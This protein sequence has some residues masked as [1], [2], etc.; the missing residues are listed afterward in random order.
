MKHALTPLAVLLLAG[1]VAS[2]PDPA[3]PA[4]GFDIPENWSADPQNNTSEIMRNQKWWTAFKSAQLD[5]TVTEAL[6]QNHDLAAAAARIDT[7]IA[8]ARLAG[9]DLYPQISGGLSASRQRTNFTGSGLPGLG[10]PDPVPVRTN[11]FGLSLDVSWELDVWGRI[12]S[13]ALAAAGEYQATQADYAGARLSIAGQTAK[14]WLAVAEANQ[15]VELARATVASFAATSR[16]AGNRAEAGVQPPS[17]KHLARSNHASAQG[18]L[19]ERERTLDA[20]KRQLEALLGRYPQGRITATTL[21]DVPPPVPAGLPADLLRRRPDLVAAE[22]RFASS[23][24]RVNSDEA[25]LYPRLAFTASG[26]TASDEFSELLS[27]DRVVWSIAGNLIQPILEG[28]RLRARVAASKGRSAEAAELFAQRVLDAFVEVESAMKADE[29]LKA[30]EDAIA[31]SAEQARLAVDVS[32][33][34]YMQGIE[35]FIV[36]LESQRRALD[37]QSALIAVRR[38][39]LDNRVN[40]YL[41]LGGGFEQWM[42]PIKYAETDSEQTEHTP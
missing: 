11:N 41:A 13:A 25:A 36:V 33:K 19:L 32:E 38:Q 31:E 21:S 4:L 23:T 30:R 15:Q 3:S 5:W 12:S 29:L 37:T 1:C 26:G 28:G 14:A 39:R 35:T 24:K 9:A 16:Q 18:L 8:E 2:P 22:R 42:P 10:T 34:R 27:G 17:D 20:A 40:L 6:N 7:A